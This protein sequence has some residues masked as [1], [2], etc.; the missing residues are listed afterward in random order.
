MRPFAALGKV[1]PLDS[2][3]FLVVIPG[4]DHDEWKRMRSVEIARVQVESIFECLA[5]T[6][7]H[8]A[9]QAPFRS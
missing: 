9:I 1:Q 7:V 5:A 2:C 6:A 3:T 8:M 4:L